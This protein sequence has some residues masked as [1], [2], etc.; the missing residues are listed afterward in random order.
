MFLYMK[1]RDLLPREELLAA[2]FLIGQELAS[3]VLVPPVTLTHSRVSASICWPE[4]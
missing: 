1:R 2:T 3:T 4:A